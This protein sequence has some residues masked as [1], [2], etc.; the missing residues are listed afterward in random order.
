MRISIRRLALLS[1]SV[2]AS[3]VTPRSTVSHTREPIVP[4]FE[5]LG[6]AAAAHFPYLATVRA[7]EQRDDAALLKLIRFS[8]RTDA[9]GSIAHG[10]VLLELREIFGVAAFDDVVAQASKEQRVATK[11]SMDA[12]T[13]FLNGPSWPNQAMQPTQHFVQPLDV[14]AA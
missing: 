5:V 13:S 7:A 2:L 3:C 1:A 6:Q 4:A 12:A 8:T 14:C 9:F 11:Q 10:A